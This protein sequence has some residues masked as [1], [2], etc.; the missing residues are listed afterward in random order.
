MLCR[1]RRASGEGQYSIRNSSVFAAEMMAFTDQ[2]PCHW[3][4]EIGADGVLV[5]LAIQTQDP[6]THTVEFAV[7]LTPRQQGRELR[8]CRRPLRISAHPVGDADLEGCVGR[9]AQQTDAGYHAFQVNRQ[10][11]DDER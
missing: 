4:R 5:T 3:G 7:E 2:F 8:T 1:R 6:S 9:D 11:V 10:S